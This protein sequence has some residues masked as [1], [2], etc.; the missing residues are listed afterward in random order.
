MKILN[1]ND[2]TATLSTYFQA[3]ML[4]LALLLVEPGTSTRSFDT[5][6]VNSYDPPTRILSEDHVSRS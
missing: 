1:S 6:I 2:E 5:G 3:I 4:P